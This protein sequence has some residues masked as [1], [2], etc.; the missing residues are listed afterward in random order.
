MK[1]Y[2]VHIQAPVLNTATST[3][4]VC[5]IRTSLLLQFIVSLR[6]VP[7]DILKAIVHIL[8]ISEGRATG[9]SVQDVQL[10]K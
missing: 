6:W 5:Q 2:H 9:N 3:G 1:L 8:S 10:S 7:G 4:R